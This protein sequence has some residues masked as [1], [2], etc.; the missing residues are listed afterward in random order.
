[1]GEYGY[2]HVWVPGPRRSGRRNTPVTPSEPSKVPFLSPTLA[3]H[4]HKPSYIRGERTKEVG[5]NRE[6][7]EEMTDG[8]DWTDDYCSRCGRRWMNHGEE[9]R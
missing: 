6:M 7:L 3:P 9:C 8:Y 4:V 5:E 2:H 1:M